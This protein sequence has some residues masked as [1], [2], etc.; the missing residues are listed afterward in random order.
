MGAVIQGAGTA[1]ASARRGDIRAPV[2]DGSTAKTDGRRGWE[3]RM[4]LP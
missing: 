1:G 3:A 2:M 4:K